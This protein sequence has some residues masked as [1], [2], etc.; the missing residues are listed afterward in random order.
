MERV[1]RIDSTDRAI[2]QLLGANSRVTFGELGHAVGLSA[3]AA[4]RRVDRLEATGVIVGYT[5]IVDD[6]KLG[7]PLEA[8][9]EMRFSGNAPV[10]AIAAIGTD[11]PEVQAVYTVAGDPDAL[12]FIKVRD[13]HDLKRVVDRL[14]SKQHVTGT[15]T[16]MVLGASSK[17]D[18]HATSRRQS[19]TR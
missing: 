7:Q 11:I 5:T 1:E 14:R 3:P 15:K 18:T 16:M 12:I 9:V 17:T 6:A 4:K 8:F 2:L 19:S 13:V 10:D